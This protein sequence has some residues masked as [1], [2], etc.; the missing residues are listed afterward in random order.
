MVSEIGRGG[1]LLRGLPLQAVSVANVYGIHPAWPL[2]I[3]R[4]TC[5]QP[6]KQF[7]RPLCRPLAGVSAFF[8][9]QD[10]SKVTCIERS[11]ALCS[12]TGSGPALAS[13]IWLVRISLLVISMSKACDII[14]WECLACIRCVV[15]L[16]MVIWAPALCL[17]KTLLPTPDH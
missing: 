10:C 12:A 17:G 15:C 16:G 2:V 8:F 11:D 9:Q 1:Q 4:A 7:V 14:C 6:Q 5:E 13:F 3:D